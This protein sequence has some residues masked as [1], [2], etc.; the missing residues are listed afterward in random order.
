MVG[1]MCE[2]NRFKFDSEEM[3]RKE[4][5]GADVRKVNKGARCEH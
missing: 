1:A 4:T 5:R 3:A 2:L